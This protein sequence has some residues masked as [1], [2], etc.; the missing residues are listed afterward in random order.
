MKSNRTDSKRQ[1]RAPRLTVIKHQEHSAANQRWCVR[2]WRFTVSIRKDN[3]SFCADATSQLCTIPV[4]E[5]SVFA[6]DNGDD[7]HGGE[8]VSLHSSCTL[9]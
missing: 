9:S 8:L 7:D 3:A 4:V 1:N 2:C 6:H 5:L